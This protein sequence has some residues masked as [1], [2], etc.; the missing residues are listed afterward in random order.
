MGQEVEAAADGDQLGFDLFGEAAQAID[1][2]AVVRGIHRCAVD[3]NAVKTRRA[4]A[5]MGDMSA[6]FSRRHDDR[7]TRPGRGHEGVEIGKSARSDTDFRKVRL[8]NL[9]G[10]FGG[11]DLDLFDR[12]QAHFV[13]VTGITKGGPG[14][15]ALRKRGLGFRVHDI[16]RRVEVDAVMLVNHP[17][18]RHQ[19]VNVVRNAVRGFAVRCPP[20]WIE[21]NAPRLAEPSF[22]V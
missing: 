12:L 9:G 1:I 11:D 2:D 18:F 8:E 7:V 17:V 6:D 5:M 15:Q 10:Q 22:A 21:C 4:R 16:G 19:G 13:F 20:R 3:L 14:A